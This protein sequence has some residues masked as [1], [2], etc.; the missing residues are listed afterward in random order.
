MCAGEGNLSLAMER[1]GFKTKAFD[2]TYLLISIR[3]DSSRCCGLI[4]FWLLLMKFLEKNDASR[5]ITMLDLV[6]HAT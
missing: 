5:S 3:C 6:I 1:P 4:Y 2:D